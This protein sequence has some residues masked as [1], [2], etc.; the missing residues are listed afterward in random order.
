VRRTTTGASYGDAFLAALGMG[1]V[2]RADIAAW[3][4]VASEFVADPANAAVYRRQ[5]EVFRALYERTGDLMHRL[6]N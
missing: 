3:N 1:D 4:P 6:A 5:Y 2:R